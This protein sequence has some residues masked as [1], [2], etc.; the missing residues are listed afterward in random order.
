MKEPWGGPSLV[1][2]TKSDTPG[3]GHHDV[4]TSEVTEGLYGL[5]V[6]VSGPK[7]KQ[8]FSMA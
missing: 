5:A 3:I 2:S 6:E 7:I 4:E 1:Q 8:E